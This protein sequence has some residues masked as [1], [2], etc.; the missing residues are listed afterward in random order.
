MTRP[1]RFELPDLSAFDTIIDVRSPAEYAE[2]HVPGAIS[3]PA[4]SDSERAR[5]GTIYTQESPFLARK[6]GAALVARNVANHLDTALRDKPGDWRPLVYCWRG[7][8]RSGSVATILRQIGWRVEVI[9]GGYRTYRRAVVDLVQTGPLPHRLVLVDG[10]TGTAKTDVLTMLHDRG[11]QTVDLEGLANH[12]GSFLGA[13]TGGQPSQKAFESALWTAFRTLD[14]ARPVLLEAESSKIGALNLPQALWTAM[15]SAPRITI[16]APVAARA[17][18]L[19]QSYA[20]LTADSDALKE[21]L[22]L[23]KRLC[24]NETVARWQALVDEGRTEQ[25]AAELVEQHY[26]PAYAR[27]RRKENRPRLAQVEAERLDDA[28]IAAL[29]DRIAALV[30]NLDLTA[31]GGDTPDLD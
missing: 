2:D 16:G 8:Q 14:P 19:T 20:D 12:R 25:L 13:R 26:D 15:K 6:I 23:L 5:V 4:L 9:P 22:A 17:T 30:D 29:A 1:E 18:Y 31:A 11:V 28:G 3:L 21:R 10:N 27:S 24:G 7:G